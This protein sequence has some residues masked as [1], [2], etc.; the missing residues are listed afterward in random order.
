[1]RKVC[2]T[3]ICPPSLEEHVVDF[4]LER[5]AQPLFTTGAVRDFGGAHGTLSSEEQVLGS[6]RAVA[7]EIQIAHD[8]FTALRESLVSQF[9]G[10]A[11]RFWA[12]ALLEQGSC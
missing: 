2:L 9:A 7:I 5:V 10:S 11:L 12:T 1:M 6:R 3:L 4:L 8:E